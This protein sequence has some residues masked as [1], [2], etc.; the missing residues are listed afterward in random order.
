MCQIDIKSG[1]VCVCDKQASK[2]LRRTMYTCSEHFVMKNFHAWGQRVPR[3][4][5]IHM[6]KE[7]SSKAITECPF[8]AAY[9][10]R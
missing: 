8:Q 7:D 6:L 1:A 4:F 5:K 9:I 2:G 10:L 3:A